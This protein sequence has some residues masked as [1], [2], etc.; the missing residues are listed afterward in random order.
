M[1]DRLDDVLNAILI[2][3]RTFKRIKINFGW[4][5]VYN[6]I[7]VPVAMGVFYPLGAVL[8]PKVDGKISGF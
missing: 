6:I 3:K 8:R 5:F 1:K 7:L 2:A 4:A